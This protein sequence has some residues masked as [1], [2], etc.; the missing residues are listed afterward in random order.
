MIL[1]L[2]CLDSVRPGTYLAHVSPEIN[3]EKLQNKNKCKSALNLHKHVI[4]LFKKNAYTNK[5]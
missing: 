3:D 1:V 2:C 4:G 5:Q